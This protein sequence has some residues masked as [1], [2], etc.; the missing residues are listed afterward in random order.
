MERVRGKLLLAAVRVL[1]GGER[2][3]MAHS[4]SLY[5]CVRGQRQGRWLTG[6]QMSLLLSKC[7]S[8]ERS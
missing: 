6:H 7:S 2:R 3:G 8:R 1:E 5:V 4:L